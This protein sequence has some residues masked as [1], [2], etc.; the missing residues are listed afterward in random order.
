[1]VVYYI[2]FHIFCAAFAYAG[3]FAL[4]QRKYKDIAEENYGKDFYFC[5][6]FAILLGPAALF[7]TTLCTTFF[8]WGLKWK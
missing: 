7:A 3:E 2:I 1:M 6:I 4:L 8:R 5:S